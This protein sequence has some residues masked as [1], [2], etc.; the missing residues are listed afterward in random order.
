M[1]RQAP[2]PVVARAGLRPPGRLTGAVENVALT[3]DLDVQIEIPA[4]HRRDKVARLT[5]AFVV[6]AEPWELSGGTLVVL[7]LP[8]HRPA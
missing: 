2:G 1:L 4:G 6:E 3:Q 5:D 8:G 7:R